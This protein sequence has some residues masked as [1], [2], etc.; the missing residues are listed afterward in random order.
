[1]TTPP[2]AVLT[3]P[4]PWFRRPLALGIGSTLLAGC[5]VCGVIANAT[6]RSAPVVSVAGVTPAPATTEAP[7][8]QVTRTSRSTRPTLTALPTGTLLP[9]ATP[10]PTSVPTVAASVSDAP[11]TVGDTLLA[12]ERAY[13]TSLVPGINLIARG[14]QTVATQLQKPDLADEV[15]RATFAVG[16]VGVQSGH[17]S[18]VALAPP[19]RLRAF[20]GRLTATTGQCDTAVRQV[21]RGIDTADVDLLESAVVSITGCATGIAERNQE[22]QA[23]TEP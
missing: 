11:L 20:H 21:T 22:M 12:E 10:A 16:V 14:L 7:A 18:I 8:A 9:S 15:W 5:C 6:P 2:P 4:R 3:P 23:L 1:M 17:E 13:F 19:P